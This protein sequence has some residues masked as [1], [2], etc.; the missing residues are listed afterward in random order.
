M[1]IYTADQVKRD[2]AKWL[3]SYT[4]WRV[5]P[6]VISLERDEKQYNEN[7]LAKDQSTVLISTPS[8]GY[9]HFMGLTGGINDQAVSIEV[10]S[11]KSQSL[12]SI[13]NDVAKVMHNHSKDEGYIVNYLRGTH[14][15]H[16]DSR[17]MFKNTMDYVVSRVFDYNI[18]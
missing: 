1:T 15:Q 13:V 8:D 10:F 2:I 11:T 9:R 4:E 7:F 12:E 18:E 16:L 14:P 3:E 6:G 17:Q 5:K